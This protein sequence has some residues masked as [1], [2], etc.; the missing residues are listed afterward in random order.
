VSYTQLTREQRYQIY[1]LK[2]ADH[3]RTE[4]ASILGVHKSTVSREL[5]RNSGRRGYRPKQAHELATE[6]K[7]AAYRPRISDR[8]WARVERLLRQEWSPEQIAGRL[9]LEGQPAVSHERI[10]QH[11]YADKRGGGMLHLCLRCRKKRRKRYGKHSRRGQMPN[12]TG[13]EARPAV[14]DAKRRVGD[15]EA[16]TIIGTAH[17]GA[18][19]SLTERKSKLVRLK[20]VKRNTAEAVAAASLSLL[21]GLAAR[22]HTITSDNGRE[23][24]SHERIAA[25]LSAKFYFAHPYASWER[26]LNENTNGLV[27]Q[28]FPKKSDFSKIAARQIERVAERLNNRPR[29]TLGYKTPNEVFFKRSLVALQT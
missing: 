12:R 28:Y 8:T 14:V 22:V 19:L 15:W 6:R 2:K 4:I 25:G 27:R 21:G 10:Y 16:D 13:I 17:R 29:K 18:I 24:A 1:A 9:K 3:N 11:I 20:K 5:S 26:G 7:L 23:F